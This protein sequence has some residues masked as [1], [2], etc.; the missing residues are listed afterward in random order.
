MTRPEAERE[1]LRASLDAAAILHWFDAGLLEK[2][3]EIPWTEARS[4]VHTLMQHSFVEPYRG[5]SDKRFNLHES[6]R[7]GWRT[8]LAG[9]RLDRF[10]AVSARA[11]SCFADGMTPTDRIE[12]IYHLLCG[13]PDLGVSKLEELDRGWSAAR[14][15]DRY[16]LA[17]ALQELA[18][19]DLI[20]GRARA[21]SL[22]TIG[23][24]RHTRGETAQL[25]PIA[26]EALRLASESGD[27]SAEADARCLIGDVLRVQGDLGPARKAYDE[28]LSIRRHLAEA[29]PN[30]ANWQR[31]LAVAYRRVGDVVQDQGKLEAA[32]VAFDSSLAICRRLIEEDTSNA[33]WRRDFAISYSRIGRVR[34]D[35]AR[36]KSR[37]GRVVE[38][39]SELA[40]ARAA[41]EEELAIFRGLTE[42]DPLNAAWWFERMVAHWRLGNAL[43]YQGHLE[44]AG[45]AFDECLTIGSRLAA[46]DPENSRLQRDLAR[47]HRRIGRVAQAQGK[48]SVAK[49]SFDQ[50]LGIS[51]RLV[52]QDSSNANWQRDLA[53]ACLRLAQIEGSAGRYDAAL[54]LY[55]ESFGIFAALVK[56]APG[57]VE[58]AEEM[59]LVETELTALRKKV[60]AAERQTP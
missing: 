6:T 49:Y 31:Q 33:S 37:I 21:W 34:R 57:F 35:L 29:D 55:E 1:P 22:L 58:W 18:D 56:R 13:D 53:L 17:S 40:A 45:M 39:Q 15:E 11:A 52:V 38:A 44:E 14:P 16:A 12:W 24:T 59:G 51:R 7:L 4:R 28:F 41:F 9:E 50:C 48:L 32:K 8:W 10:R 19:T 25:A 36:E 47:T 26:E 46:Q 60:A 2:V 30:N 23:W 54:P 42:E 43:Q 3:L 20:K 5:A 27:K